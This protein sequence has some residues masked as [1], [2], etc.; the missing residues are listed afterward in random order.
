MVRVRV[1]FRAYVRGLKLRLGWDGVRVGQG[2][3]VGLWLN[4]G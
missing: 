4:W 3:E 2:L 1:K